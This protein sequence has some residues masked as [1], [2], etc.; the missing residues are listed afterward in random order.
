MHE[1]TC[2]VFKIVPGVTPPDPLL[3]LGPWIT[4]PPPPSKIL[5]ARWSPWTINSHGISMWNVFVNGLTKECTFLRCTSCKCYCWWTY[6]PLRVNSQTSSWLDACPVW[7]SVLSK[8]IIFGNI[9]Y[10]N[11]Y[12]WLRWSSF[13]STWDSH[14]KSSYWLKKKDSVLHY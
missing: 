2:T 12:C 5:A 9:P 8:R 1:I 6:L 4:F 7:H 14:T 13:R 3:V 11:S 10:I